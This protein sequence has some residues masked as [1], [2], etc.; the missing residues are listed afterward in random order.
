MAT[1][2]AG[3]SSTRWRRGLDGIEVALG[4]TACAADNFN[5]A[6]V[7]VVMN[8]QTAYDLRC[9]ELDVALQTSVSGIHP[10]AQPA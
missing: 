1:G 10:L 9:A 3:L 4:G 5:S 2:R 8:L 7:Y 6:L